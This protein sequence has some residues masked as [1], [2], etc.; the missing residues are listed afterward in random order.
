MLGPDSGILHSHPLGD[1][2]QELTGILSD[3]LYTKVTTPDQTNVHFQELIAAANNKGV[4]YTSPKGK[5]KEVQS[6]PLALATNEYGL[7][8]ASSKGKAAVASSVSD[9]RIEDSDFPQLSVLMV[10]VQC[11]D[12]YSHAVF[13][14]F[15]PSSPSPH[16]ASAL[17]L[18]EALRSSEDAEAIVVNLDINDMDCQEIRLATARLPIFMDELPNYPRSRTG[19]RQLGFLQEL[20]PNCFIKPVLVGEEKEHTLDVFGQDQRQD[21]YVLYIWTEVSLLRA[22]D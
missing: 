5:E 18:Y 16:S 21:I 10:G 20:D 22:H 15:T 13:Q 14:I 19:F 8:P 3:P 1:I 9:Y 11:P 17:D 7:M 2:G 12:R 4:V 6:K